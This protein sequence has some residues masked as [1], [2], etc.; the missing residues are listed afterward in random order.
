M[1]LRVAVAVALAGRQEVVEVLVD[2]GA[3]VADAV[4][5]AR[6]PGR[7]PGLVLEG[8]QWAV[9]GKP[10]AASSRLRDRDR[11]ELLRPLAADAKDQRRSRARLKPSSR[12]SRSG[13]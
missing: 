12:R 4:R 8:A 7:F 5:A 6:L 1:T 3:T 11:V 2:D 10:C 9:W 13:P